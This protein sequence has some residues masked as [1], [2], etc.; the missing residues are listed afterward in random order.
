VPPRKL[1]PGFLVIGLAKRIGLRGVFHGMSISQ[2]LAG[3]A[4]W[5]SMLSTARTAAQRD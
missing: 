3:F 4:S 1:R 2:G 5:G